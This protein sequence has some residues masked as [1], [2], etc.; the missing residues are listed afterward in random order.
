VELLE[1]IKNMEWWKFRELVRSRSQYG[2]E[3]IDNN[4]AT[5]S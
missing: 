3:L 4:E 1:D 2:A 5:Q